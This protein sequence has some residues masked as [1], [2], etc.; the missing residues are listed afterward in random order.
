MSTETTYTM[1]F[2]ICEIF[3]SALHSGIEPPNGWRYPLVA[4]RDN[5]SLTETTS[6]HVNCL[7]TRRLPPVG[8][9]LCW[10]TR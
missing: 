4:G 10:A 8:C 7:K 9:T 1:T 5:A 6:S 3:L 2:Y